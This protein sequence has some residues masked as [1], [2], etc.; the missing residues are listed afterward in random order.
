MF[1]RCKKMACDSGSSAVEF[2]LVGPTF[3]GLVFG[4][5]W[6][7]WVA[8]C[9]YSVHHALDIGARALQLKPTTTQNE[10]LNLVRSNV[11]IGTD[12]QNITVSLTFD[13][14]SSGTQLAHVTATFPLSFSIPF[15]GVHSINY[16]ASTTVPV[17]A[18]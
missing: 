10:L 7:G 6:I 5:F 1:V 16:S 18:S 15:F 14:I 11:S 8:F 3:L 9:T 17:F 4:V 13:A 2:A 12:S